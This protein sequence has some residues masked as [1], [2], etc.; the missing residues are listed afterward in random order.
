M[1][2]LKIDYCFLYLISKVWYKQVFSEEMQGEKKKER[3][4]YFNSLSQFRINSIMIGMNCS[5]MHVCGF[6]LWLLLGKKRKLFTS[7]RL[8]GLR[9]GWHKRWWWVIWKDIDP[10]YA[11]TKTCTPGRFFF[12][13]LRELCGYRLTDR[14][15]SATGHRNAWS[16]CGWGRTGSV[17][18]RVKTE[19]RQST[20]STQPR[21]TTGKMR[22]GC[23]L[24]APELPPS[25]LFSW[26][27]SK[28]NTMGILKINIIGLLNELS[29]YELF[30][31]Y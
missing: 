13:L 31:K 4:C 2:W 11:F 7:A 27:Y 14:S 12:C 18:V 5:L 23:V 29:M 21:T 15:L 22:K 20:A 28:S 16:M 26:K 25:L 9:K 30:F 24:Q 10:N 8:A 1:H 17:W 3:K 19:G 6:C